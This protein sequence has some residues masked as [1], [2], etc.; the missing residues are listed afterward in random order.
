M[1]KDENLDH[2]TA[3][4][5]PPVSYEQEIDEYHKKYEDKEGESKKKSKP[6]GQRKKR[7]GLR[8]LM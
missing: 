6:K 5:W 1:L 3:H 7:F 8:G 2:V 4:C